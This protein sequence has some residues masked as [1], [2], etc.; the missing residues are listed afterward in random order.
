MIFNK[1]K[2]LCSS[3][4]CKALILYKLYKMKTIEINGLRENVKHYQQDESDDYYDQFY[5]SFIKCHELM[6]HGDC[7]DFFKNL[8]KSYGPVTH[9]MKLPKFVKYVCDGIDQLIILV[10]NAM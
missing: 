8:I 6:A 4:Q 3:L 1:K 10:K 9:Q 5:E 7:V 2:I